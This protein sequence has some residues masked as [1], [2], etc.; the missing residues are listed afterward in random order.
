[1]EIRKKLKESKDWDRNN[2]EKVTWIVN[3]NYASN[4]QQ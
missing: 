4:N 1:M 2:Q 3:S